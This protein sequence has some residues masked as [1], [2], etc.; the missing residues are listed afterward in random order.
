MLRYDHLIQQKIKKL[1]FLYF[2][3]LDRHL[4]TAQ[5]Y[6]KNFKYI[7]K[8]VTLLGQPCFQ[9]PWDLTEVRK[10]KTGIFGC[11]KTLN[12]FEKDV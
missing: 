5:N 4:I 2:S 10:E 3:L 12:Y 11:V 1:I 9:G 7:K 8:S 6:L